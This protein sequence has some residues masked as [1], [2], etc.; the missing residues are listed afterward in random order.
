MVK[1]TVLIAIKSTG[2]KLAMAERWRQRGDATRGGQ[3]T[4]SRAD[5]K[6]D[7]GQSRSSS[8]VRNMSLGRRELL[9]PSL[10]MRELLLTRDA[11]SSNKSTKTQFVRIFYALLRAKVS[12]NDIVQLYKKV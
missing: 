3:A 5:M 1:E 10:L 11:V 4:I 7:G 6:Q 9:E 8:V 2:T 12:F